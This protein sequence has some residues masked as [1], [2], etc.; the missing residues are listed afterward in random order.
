M[1]C[2]LLIIQ[3]V[4]GKEIASNLTKK[5]ILSGLKQSTMYRVKVNAFSYV[6]E[7]EINF[8]EV[9]YVEELRCEDRHV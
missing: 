6:G 7:G 4:L 9:R 5:T 1:S 2:F 8:V 3:E